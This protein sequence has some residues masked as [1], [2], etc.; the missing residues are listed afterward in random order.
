MMVVKWCTKEL[1]GIDSLNKNSKEKAALL[2][3]GLRWL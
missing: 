2:P 1:R 3:G